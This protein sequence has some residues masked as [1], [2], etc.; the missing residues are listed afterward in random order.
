M[1]TTELDPRTQALLEAYG[2]DRELFVRFK[3]LIGD[4]Q[5]E[6]LLG[7]TFVGD[8][9]QPVVAVEVRRTQAGRSVGNVV[10]LVPHAGH[11]ALRITPG[12]AHGW[13]ARSYPFVPES[14]DDYAPLLLPWKDGAMLYRYDGQQLVPAPQR[15]R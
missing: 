7:Y 6:I 14:S 15:A 10:A 1:I 2:F 12:R 5:R 11:W 3:Q 13:D 8:G 4:V 9:V